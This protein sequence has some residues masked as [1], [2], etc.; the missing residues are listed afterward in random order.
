MIE[1]ALWYLLCVE[2][3]GRSLEQLEEIF[4]ARN[5]VRA[6]IQTQKIVYKEGGDLAVIDE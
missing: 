3:N 1:A 5:P 4:A 6:S 2:T